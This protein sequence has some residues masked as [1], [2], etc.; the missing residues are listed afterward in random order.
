MPWGW[1]GAGHYFY[2]LWAKKINDLLLGSLIKTVWLF[3]FFFFF[4]LGAPMLFKLIISLKLFPQ[5]SLNDIQ[6]SLGVFRV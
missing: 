6:I 2:H 1:G 5:R 3:F 4:F